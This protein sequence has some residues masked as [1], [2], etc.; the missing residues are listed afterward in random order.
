MEDTSPLPRLKIVKHF[1]PLFALKNT[2][3]QIEN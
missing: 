2:L 3:I 1:P